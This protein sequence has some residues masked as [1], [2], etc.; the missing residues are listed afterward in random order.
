MSG[1]ARLLRTAD[2]DVHDFASTAKLFDSLS[3]EGYDLE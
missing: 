2:H 3:S 1:L